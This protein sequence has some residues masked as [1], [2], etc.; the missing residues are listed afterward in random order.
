LIIFDEIFC[1]NEI[2]CRSSIKSMS[3]SLVGYTI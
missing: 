2:F 3:L 1:R